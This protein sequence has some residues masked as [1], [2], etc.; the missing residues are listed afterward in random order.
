MEGLSK[1]TYKVTVTTPTF[2]SLALIGVVKNS[3]SYLSDW[4]FDTLKN[5]FEWW[6]ITLSFL[7]FFLSILWLIC[8][9]CKQSK[10]PTKTI[11]V[12][13]YSLMDSR[14][15]E[16][17]VSTIIPWITIMVDN[18]DFKALFMCVL[19]QCILISLASYTHSNYNI[20]C[21]ILGYRFYEVKTENNVFILLSKRCLKNKKEITEYVPIDGYWGLIK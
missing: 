9:F 3:E 20:L 16:Q 15:M 10:R 11:K 5:N 4:T 1:F 8:F 6:A 14:G 7:F 21:S 13:S 12:I 17:I 19:I 18:V 2:F